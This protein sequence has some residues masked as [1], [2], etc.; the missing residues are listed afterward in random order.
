MRLSLVAYISFSV[1][2][3]AHSRATA[4]DGRTENSATPAGVTPSS[5]WLYFDDKLNS[6]VVS[7]APGGEISE[8]ATSELLRIYD[9]PT[10]VVRIA[11]PTAR[12][13]PSRRAKAGSRAETFRPL[14]E[15]VAR[16]Y[17]IDPDLIHSI[18]DVE[19]R[20][21]PGAVSPKGAQGLMQVMPALARRFGVAE[22]ARDLADPAINLKVAAAY[23]KT[24]QGRYGNNLPLIL[25]AYNAGE[26]AVQRHGGAIPP[27]RETQAYVRRVLDLYGESLAGR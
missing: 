5:S 18:A 6:S 4:A 21:N 17:A 2:F 14:I 25:A 10:P 27:Y 24:L 16:S 7:A 22:P 8:P 23:L 20:H 13:A 9:Q 19:S 26:G 12:T 3:T 1:V 11:I 15:D